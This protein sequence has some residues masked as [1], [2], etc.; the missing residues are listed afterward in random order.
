MDMDFKCF[1]CLLILLSTNK[2]G[3]ISFG[4]SNEPFMIDC[5]QFKKVPCP[6]PVRP[7]N[8][9]NSVETNKTNKLVF[10]LSM[11]SCEKENGEED[12]FFAV[13]SFTKDNR[14]TLANPF[15]MYRKYQQCPTECEVNLVYK[16]K[17]K[18]NDSCKIYF[19]CD[20]RVSN[21]SVFSWNCLKWNQ[22]RDGP[23]ILKIIEDMYKPVNS[24]KIIYL[25]LLVIVVFL[26]VISFVYV[27]F[28]M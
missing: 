9:L 27:K 28:V 5:S 6:S 1:V 14:Q 23:N 18:T 4:N 8:V 3:V 16:E 21:C 17:V 15:D 2:F 22:E 10:T 13:A 7:K 19:Q 24:H 26:S 12:I 20:H 11:R 25:V